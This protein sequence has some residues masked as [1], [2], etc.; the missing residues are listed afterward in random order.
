[1]SPPLGSSF[2]HP[3]LPVSEGW[4]FQNNAYINITIKQCAH[5]TTI[6]VFIAEYR[7]TFYHFDY[8]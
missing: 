3:F 7:S 6:M 4:S 1:M 8:S 2:D 5:I